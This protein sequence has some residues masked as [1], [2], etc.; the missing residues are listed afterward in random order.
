MSKTQKEA[1]NLYK[2]SMTVE[3]NVIKI[4]MKVHLK[5][6]RKELNVH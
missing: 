3:M 6:K 2:K 1:N 5:R 4:F